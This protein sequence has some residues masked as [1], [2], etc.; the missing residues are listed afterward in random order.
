MFQYA[1]KLFQKE[2]IK[3]EKKKDEEQKRNKPKEEQGKEQS[4]ITKNTRLLLVNLVFF[5]V[6]AGGLM[7]VSGRSIFDL[8]GVSYWAAKSK[9]QP[10][11]GL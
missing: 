8:L 6:V 9:D 11:G 2:K 4:A 1:M 7:L 3:E 5:A 10:D